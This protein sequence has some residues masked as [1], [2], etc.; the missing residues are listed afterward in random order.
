MQKKGKNKFHSTQQMSKCLYSTN[1]MESNHGY[2]INIHIYTHS[3]EDT[4]EY[5]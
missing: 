2:E 1:T 3:S 5:I 4:A